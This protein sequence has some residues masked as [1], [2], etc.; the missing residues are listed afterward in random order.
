[1]MASL[2]FGRF[3][4][5]SQTL[6]FPYYFLSSKRRRFASIINP[7]TFISPLRS[8]F[9]C[10]SLILISTAFSFAASVSGKITDDNNE[11]LPGVVAELRNAKDSS[12]AK[13]NVT[14][15]KG[16]FAFANIKEG[17]YFLKT[18]LVGFNPYRGEVFNYDGATDKQIAVVK[19]SVS[20]IQLKEAE[21]S[22]IKPL[23]EVHSD[24]T[25]FNVENSINSTGSTAY[26]LLQKAPG[27]VVDNNDNISLKGRGGV[28][29][30]IDG[31]DMRMSTEE[32]G[33]FLK[34]IQSSDVESIEL[35]SNPSSK[36]EAAGTAGIINIKL[37]K[38]KNFGTNGTLTAGY[39]YGT[40]TEFSKYNTSLSLNNRSK[41]FN[42]YMNYGNN[43]GTRQSDFYLYREQN[44]FIFN[45]AT[46]FRREGL[47]QNYKAGVDYTINKKNS[48]GVMVNGN[49]GDLDGQN[50]SQN[51]ISHF[52]SELA[53]SILTSNSDVK[54]HTN[55]INGN[56]NHHF[57]DTLGHDLATD[58]DFGSYVGSR[59]ALQP[60][61]YTLGESDSV[62]AARYYRSYSPSVITINT[63]KSDYTQ[64]FLKGKLGLGYKL[65]FVKTDNNFGF[66]NILNGLEEYDTTRSNHFVYTENVYAGYVNYQRTIKKFDIQAGVRMENTA[67]EGVLK[68]ATSNPEDKDVKRSYV[69]FFPSG[70]VTYNANKTNTVGLTYSRRIERPNY[71]E[72][73]PFEYKLD[74]LSYRKGNPFLNPQYSDNFSLSHTW[75]FAYTTELGYSRT[76]DFFAQITDT[77]PGG[78]S[79]ITSKNL[80]TEEVKSINF[81]ASAQPAKWYSIYLNAGLYNQK[82]DADFGNGKT[83]NSS[84]T[85][86]NLYAQNTIKLPKDVSLEI[87][88]WYN[89]SGVWGGAYVTDPQGSMDLGLQKKLFKDQGTLKLSYTDVFLTAPWNSH[90]I[91]AGIVILAHGN[92]ES[93]QFRASFSWRFGNRQ[94]KTG[95]ARQTGS[96]EEQ[97]RI[98]GGGD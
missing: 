7:M 31:R 11:P 2:P 29:V 64:N 46:H 27:V 90:N 21:V 14:D 50:N 63:L 35:I 98:G 43:W 83:I 92:W 71:Q 22:A 58:F 82:Y 66:Y 94:M 6:T 44:P 95:R 67:S 26:E 45:S 93:Q 72:L 86:F 88:G 51:R 42:L 81:N 59:N 78:K 10:I 87:S 74:E 1:V 34:S 4:G 25:V 69:D 80:A 17:K 68:G 33:D 85:S 5:A 23:V 9:L 55:S 53:D 36:Y 20:S 39:A 16:E 24:K 73:N 61:V 12:L 91:Y 60:N 8:F 48:V 84:V 40:Q 62:I 52:N 77:I 65:S 38:N 49:Y 13:V 47:N 96:D 57:T 15:A 79:Y 76:H 19:M 54:I 97:K 18:S 41:K 70:G 89:S 30:Q 75:K 32:L 56:V 3:R 37:K 28:L